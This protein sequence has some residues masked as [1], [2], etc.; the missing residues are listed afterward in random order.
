MN[1]VFGSGACVHHA[2]H[3]L[4]WSEPL[5]PI[6]GSYTGPSK[7]I[8][9]KF[10]DPF[11]WWWFPRALRR[12]LEQY[13]SLQ[14]SPIQQKSFWPLKFINKYTP[15]ITSLSI[16]VIVFGTKELVFIKIELPVSWLSVMKCGKGKVKERIK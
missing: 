16:G 13:Y 7:I 10:P 9:A 8:I 1:F 15:D 6:P 2:L 11:W 4:Q 5:L 3:I 12:N 14:K